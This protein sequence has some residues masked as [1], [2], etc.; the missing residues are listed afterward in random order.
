MKKWNGLILFAFA[1]SALSPAVS[2]QPPAFKD[3]R[4]ASPAALQGGGFGPVE[5]AIPPGTGR[6]VE[7]SLYET[8]EEFPFDSRAR[9]AMEIRLE[10]FRRAGIR[11]LGGRAVRKPNH[12]WTYVIEYFP[13]I[14][15]GGKLPAA[16]LVETFKPSSTYWRKQDAEKA[17]AATKSRLASAGLHVLGGEVV[18][19]G[20]DHSFEIHYL[21]PNRLRRGRNERAN[22]VRF[23]GGS[24]TFESRAEAAMSEYASRFERAGIAVIRTR[25]VRRPDRDYAVVVEFVNRSNEYGPR[26]AFAIARYDAQETFSFDH[27]ALA[28]ARA[29]LPAFSVD[30]ASPLH[31]FERKVGRDYSFSID[32]LVKNL[33]RYGRS[34]PAVSVR[35]YFATESFTFER[36]AEKALEAKKAAFKAAGVA[37]LGGRAVS[38]GRDYS[39]ELDY[40]DPAR[41]EDDRRPRRR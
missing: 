41:Q 15:P 24:F 29:L 30:G 4:S 13:A 36:Q 11:T 34:Q 21:M 35:T 32:Y 1:L 39:Y 31:G 2:S 5:R 10:A 25:T 7:I 23:Q 17:F 40:F 27:Q 14:E 16:V 9:E 18:D 6:S 19:V 28:A 22:I 20:S 8:E 37:V 33:Y 26:P 3:L 38:A 12:R